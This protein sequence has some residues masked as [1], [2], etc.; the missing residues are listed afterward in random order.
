M[1]AARAG[2]TQMANWKAFSGWSGLAFVALQFVVGGIYVSF[3]TPVNA[4]D[5]TAFAAFAARNVSG[6]LAAMV[7]TA[8]AV[9]CAY[10]WLLG[11]QGV[12]KDHDDWAWNADFTF[13]IGAIAAT[14]GLLGTGLQ[15]AAVIDASS[16]PD[17]SAVRA[18]FEAGA[19][20]IAPVSA[21]PTALFVAS[22]AYGIR[23]TGALARWIGTFGYLCAAIVFLTLFSVY[24]GQD[25]ANAFSIVGI[26]TFS[27][28]ILPVFLWIGATSVALIRSE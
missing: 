5:T 3:G 25:P 26:A 13:T 18:L 7:A 17:P 22:A 23:G 2:S 14:L 12:I 15:T 20:F 11:I 27:V 4:A 16:N 19:V 10:V 21:V 8:L 9:G 28:G 1:E 24:F 6:S